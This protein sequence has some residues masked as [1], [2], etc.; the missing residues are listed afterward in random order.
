M[1]SNLEL[2]QKSHRRFNP[3]T[4]EWVLVSPHRTQRPWQGATETV[5]SI[6]RPQYDPTCYLCP[7]NQRA[8]GVR[9][10]QYDST[11][12]FVNDFAALQADVAVGRMDAQNK[13]LLVAEGEA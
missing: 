5:A 3:L 9:N 13:G 1:Q 4:N 12:V 2:S 7:G 8:G 10:P 6:E 11:F